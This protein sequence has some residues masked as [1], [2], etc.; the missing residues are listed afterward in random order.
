M[1]IDLLAETTNP[2]TISLVAE[3][4]AAIVGHVAFSP[5]SDAH[6][7]R[8][9]GY[10]LAPLAVHPSFQ[11]RRIGTR[12]IEQGT[13]QLGNLAVDIVFVY[14]D[15]GFYRRFGFRPDGALEYVPP[16]KLQYPF[17]WEPCVQFDGVGNLSLQR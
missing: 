1:A 14:G 7:D 8:F 4:G 17:G 10:I 15:P 3:S 9:L 16:Y 11:K 12:L 13:E 6:A 5:A 2:E